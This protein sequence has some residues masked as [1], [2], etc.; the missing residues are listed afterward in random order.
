MFGGLN[1]GGFIETIECL[2]L[3]E[4]HRPWDSFRTPEFT[5]RWNMGVARISQSE[6]AILGGRHEGGVLGEILLF[7]TM[8]R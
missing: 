5:P 6:I 4:E 7:D 1:G 3:F 8:T 2:N